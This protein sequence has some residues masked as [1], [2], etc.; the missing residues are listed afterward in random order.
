MRRLLEQRRSIAL[1]KI[2][3]ECLFDTSDTNKRLVALRGVFSRHGWWFIKHRSFFSVSL[4]KYWLISLHMMCH[5]PSVFLNEPFL[6]STQ[7]LCAYIGSRWQ[8]S[9][10]RWRQKKCSL[11]EGYIGHWSRYWALSE[12]RAA[13][14]RFQILLCV[15]FG[16]FVPVCSSWD[17]ILAIFHFCDSMNLVDQAPQP[18]NGLVITKTK[19][20]TLM[21]YNSSYRFNYTREQLRSTQLI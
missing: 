2:H 16:L 17:H 10:R 15:N 11:W 8:V 6:I 12:Y 19:R 18:E 21:W 4:L 9:Y 1:I 13:H 14:T 5:L 3:L 7:I 20:E